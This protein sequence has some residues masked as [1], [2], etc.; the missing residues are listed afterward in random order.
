MHYLIDLAEI[1]SSGQSDKAGL[2]YFNQ[3][4]RTRA[5]LGR[6]LTFQIGFQTGL[7]ILNG[8]QK[9]LPNQAMW[10]VRGTA[11][12]PGCRIMGC[13]SS[14]TAPYHHPP[15]IWSWT[16]PVLYTGDEHRITSHGCF[17]CLLSPFGIEALAF[18]ESRGAHHYQGFS[19]VIH[20]ICNMQYGLLGCPIEQLC[21][22]VILWRRR[23]NKLLLSAPFFKILH[24]GCLSSLIFVAVSLSDRRPP[25]SF[26]LVCL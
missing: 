16:P 17:C 19:A 8:E 14:P 15:L 20:H 2:Q 18:K 24:C 26:H 25:N 13:W 12:L 22:N 4:L 10:T 6:S 21:V 7:E 1:Q 3:S 23:R 5:N 11:F 9:H